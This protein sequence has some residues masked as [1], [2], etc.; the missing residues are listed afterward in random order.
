MS[1][2]LFIQYRPI[3]AIMNGGDQCTKRNYD[4]LCRVLGNENVDIYYIHQEV[5]HSPLWVYAKGMCYMP[6]GYFLGMTPRRLQSLVRLAEAY[7]Y[8]FIDRSVF[9]IVAKELKKNG[10]KG[11]II[12]HFH[13]VETL[14]FAA[15][16]S[17]G[18]PLRKVL[19]HCADVNDEAACRYSDNIVVL[20]NRDVEALKER[21][22][23]PRVVEIPI[24]LNDTFK[25]IDDKTDHL[26]VVRQQPLCV[27]LGSYFQPNNEGILWFV[28][29]VLPHVNIRMQIVGKN[30]ARLKQEHRELQDIEVISD[31][32]DL[33][34]Y[35]ID[36]DIMILPIFA[37][38]GMKVKTC[39]S[40][41]YGKNIIGTVEAFEGYK[42]DYERVGGRCATAEE[43]R[44]A[45]RRIV[46]QSWPRFNDYSRQTYL[47]HYSPQAL[48]LQWKE[49]VRH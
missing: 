32:P 28:H 40:L 34:P 13:N 6:F 29:E 21:Y 2:L 27:F 17:A 5:E 36:A 38:S 49:V 10:Y 18:I 1:K 45:I 31:A 19:I 24:T 41:M 22:T 11:R 37:G 12:T 35:L 48:E 25:A 4:M 16:I 8:V 26:S 15:K 3:G 7:D 47:A 20:N 43:F 42:L 33:T 23:L 44:Q 39:E 46:E 30:M 9:G 14:Y